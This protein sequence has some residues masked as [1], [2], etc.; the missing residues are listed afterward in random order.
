MYIKKINLEEGNYSVGH[1]LELL[2]KGI[3]RKKDITKLLKEIRKVC[4]E[5]N[6]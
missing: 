4:R 1:S 3:D 5:V 6:Q 2:I